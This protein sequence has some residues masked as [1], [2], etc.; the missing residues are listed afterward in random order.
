MHGLADAD[1]LDELQ[2]RYSAVPDVVRQEPELLALL[3][4]VLRADVRAIET[5]APLTDRKVR[6]PVHVYGGRDDR[7]PRPDQLP[8]WQRVAEREVRVRVFPGDHFYVAAQ[9][10]ALAEDMAACWTHV[11]VPAERA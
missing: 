9:R 6:C 10:D 8:G 1:F 4:P 7:H 3:L 11:P 5:Y 2:R